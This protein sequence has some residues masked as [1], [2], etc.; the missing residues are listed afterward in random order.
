[1]RAPFRGHGY[2]LVAPGSSLALVVLDVPPVEVFICAMVKSRVLLGMENN[3][4]PLIGILISWGPINPYGLGL[5]FPSPIIWKY[6]ELIDPIA[7]VWK[8]VGIEMLSNLQLEQL[9]LDTKSP[10]TSW[11]QYY[12]RGR[13]SVLGTYCLPS[14]WLNQPSWKIC[15]SQIGFIFPK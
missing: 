13:E 7:H 11:V 12:W 14:W 8:P 9:R 5:I 3:L 1:M 15:E 4:P 10:C 2:P 6:R